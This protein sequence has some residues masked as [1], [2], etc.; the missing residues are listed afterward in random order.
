[1]GAW[2]TGLFSDDVACDIRAE[3]RALCG[4]GCT[5]PKATRQIL[6]HW[7]E[8][9]EDEEDG[10]VIWLALGSLQ[11]DRG[12][13][14]P[15]VKKKALRIIDRGEDLKRWEADGDTR[16][17]RQREKVLQKL[18]AKLTSPQPVPK[19]AKVKRQ[20]VRTAAKPAKAA[21]A[22]M[23][24]RVGEVY[25]YRLRSGDWI[26][27]H[28]VAVS[29]RGSEEDKK[30]TMA[31]FDWQGKE[32]P[33]AEQIFQLSYRKPPATT[34]AWGGEVAKIG[35]R[36]AY[37]IEV[38]HR[39]LTGIPRKRLERLAVKRKPPFAAPAG[40]HPGVLWRLLDDQLKQDLGL[41]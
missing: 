14:Q 15:L 26:L 36:R 30:P 34:I 10:P 8:A 18:R 25:G 9:V 37:C 28:V 23:V 27:L 29:D 4:Q 40:W 35:E 7:R 21:P 6:E 39:A 20:L 41:Q 13:L 1:M 12:A 2:G 3:F 24:W 22:P 5:V 38:A 31:V 17:L 32:F 11:W 19:Q 16:N 33:P